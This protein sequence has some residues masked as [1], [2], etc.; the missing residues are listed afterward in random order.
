MRGWRHLL[1]TAG[2]TKPRFLTAIATSRDLC[3][4][5][6]F[7]SSEAARNPAFGTT[8]LS[9]ASDSFQAVYS[10]MQRQYGLMA[11]LPAVLPESKETTIPD[12]VAWSSTARRSAT[13]KRNGASAAGRIA[14]SMSWFSICRPARA[15]SLNCSRQTRSRPDQPYHLFERSID[16]QTGYCRLFVGTRKAGAAPDAFWPA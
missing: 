10:S 14:S 16:W 11:Y 1:G 3:L 9:S 13:M 8:C 15:V 5:T 6:R 4:Q 2:D 7:G 12:E